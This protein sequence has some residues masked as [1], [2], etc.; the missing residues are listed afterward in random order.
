[1]LS[2]TRNNRLRNAW[3]CPYCR[4]GVD[5]RSFRLDPKA[6]PDFFVLILH[7]PAALNGNSRTKASSGRSSGPT[8]C[9]ARPPRTRDLPVLASL[10][11]QVSILGC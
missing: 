3:R 2:A 1:M 8:T 7:V 4:T 5:G 10:K 11:R 6:L 9:C